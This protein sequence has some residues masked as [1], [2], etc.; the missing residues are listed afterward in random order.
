MIDWTKP[1]ETVEDGQPARVLGLLSL[2]I[3]SLPIE[4]DGP[5]MVWVESDRN[6]LGNI[7]L[8]D[9]RGFRCDDRALFSARQ[10]PFIR[11]VKVKKEGWVLMRP[12]SASMDGRYLADDR[13]YASEAEAKS[14]KANWYGADPGVKP[15]HLT[16]EE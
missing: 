15:V 8:A 4:P 9:N 12:S 10:E 13:V 2:A 6:G 1:I 16:W 5:M 14:A 7:F 3:P 11:N